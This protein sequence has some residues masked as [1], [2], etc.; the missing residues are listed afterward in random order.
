MAV[1]APSPGDGLISAGDVRRAAYCAGLRRHGL[2]TREYDYD[3]IRFPLV[4]K[5]LR[6]LREGSRTPLLS[7][8]GAGKIS[9]TRRSPKEFAQPL[10]GMVEVRTHSPLGEVHPFSDLPVRPSLQVVQQDHLAPVL[11]NLLECGEQTIP[12]VGLLGFAGR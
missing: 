1:S 4:K 11:R 5:I 8:Q 9:R 12:Q 2:D 10:T 6:K 3:T 7:R